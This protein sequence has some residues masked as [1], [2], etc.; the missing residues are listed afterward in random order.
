MLASEDG[1]RCWPGS[2]DSGRDGRVP[3]SAFRH[4]EIGRGGCIRPNPP[5]RNGLV[6]CSSD[7]SQG[8]SILGALGSPGEGG[9][10]QSP[11]VCCSLRY[12]QPI[13]LCLRGYCTFRK[14]RYLTF[15]L[16][17]VSKLLRGNR[18]RIG[19]LTFL[20]VTCAY[21]FCHGLIALVVTPAQS[22]FLPEETVF[23]SLLYLP[24]GVRVLA[25]WALGWRAIPAL[26]VGASIA[27]WL[28]TP[29]DRFNFLEPVLLESILAGAVSAFLAFELVRLAGFDFYA[30]RARKLS[31]KGMITIG[32]ISS[33]INSL[34][35]TL[36]FSGLIGLEK[37]VEVLILYAVGDLVGL[38]VCMVA[39]M[40]IFRW[41]RFYRG[42][43]S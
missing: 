29:T 12:R 6:S 25:T 28:F 7:L 20:I 9:R 35:Q 33:V 4:G 1:S 10:L 31:W 8:A 24:H 40:F 23:A 11:T 36:I 37:L 22:I 32:A 30:G 18:H 3:C 26:V 42:V 16:F 27:E 34:A 41:S 2:V 19:L 15:L 5:T 13:D 39:L 21:V 17:R 43:E 14:V 38:V